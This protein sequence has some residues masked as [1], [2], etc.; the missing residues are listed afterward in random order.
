MAVFYYTLNVDNPGYHALVHSSFSWAYT[1]TVKQGDTIR[2]TLKYPGNQS[3][4]DIIQFYSYSP[5]NLDMNSNRNSPYRLGWER[6]SGGDPITSGITYQTQAIATDNDNYIRGNFFARRT[7]GGA[8]A[9]LGVRFLMV[10]TDGTLGFDVGSYSAGTAGTATYRATPVLDGWMRG[11]YLTSSNNYQYIPTWE[12]FAGSNVLS[13]RWSGQ[14]DSEA[15]ASFQMGNNLHWKIVDSTDSHVNSNDFFTS[16]GTLVSPQDGDTITIHPKS[17]V[18]GTYYLNLYHFNTEG[19]WSNGLPPYATNVYGYDYELISQKAFTVS[20][21]TAPTLSSGAIQYTTGYLMPTNPVGMTPGASVTY[22]WSVETRNG[23]KYFQSGYAGFYSS[24]TAGVGGEWHGS[25]WT[26]YAVATLGGNSATSNTVTFTLPTQD[27]NVTI[28]PQF[29]NSN[30]SVQ[31]P[32]LTVNSGSNNNSTIYFVSSSPPLGSLDNMY[33]RVDADGQG[34]D[35]DHPNTIVNGRTF[36][37]GNSRHVRSTSGGAGQFMTDIPNQQTAG[38]YYIYSLISGM[39]PVI[40]AYTGRSYI[41]ERPDTDIT[42]TPSKTNIGSYA[43]R[44]RD[45]IS[46]DISN[47]IPNNTNTTYRLL[48]VAGT[49]YDPYNYSQPTVEVSAANGSWVATTISSYDFDPNDGSFASNLRDW[50]DLPADGHFVEY[51]CQARIR[52]DRGGVGTETAFQ[53]CPGATFT[54]TVGDAIVAPQTSSLTIP[55]PNVS[56]NTYTA[57]LTLSNAG[58]G[59]G[60]LQYAIERNDSTPDNWVNA[61]YDSQTSFDA[62][63][64]RMNSPGTLYGHARRISGS[65]IYSA[66]TVQSITALSYLSPH[67]TNYYVSSPTLTSNN[68]DIAYNAS[69]VTI[70]IMR[71]GGFAAHYETTYKL[72]QNNQQVSSSVTSAGYSSTSYLS[73]TLS[74]T[75]LPA[76]SY[77]KTYQLTANRP[78]NKGGDGADKN[79][80]LTFNITRNSQGTTT[81]PT[82]PTDPGQPTGDY[83]LLVYGPDGSTLILSPNYR[84]FNIVDVQ[85]SLGFVKPNGTET[86]NFKK[87]YDVDVEFGADE[88]NLIIAINSQAS[89]DG[90]HFGVERAPGGDKSV[91][92]IKSIN[93]GLWVNDYLNIGWQIIRI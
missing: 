81:D 17:S 51:Q 83:G 35:F 27:E 91:V 36:D 62:T 11:E 72:K 42:V 85:T 12:K 49:K 24:P 89:F 90:A 41:V 22:Y 76:A 79:T 2:L 56:S 93:N 15:V 68:L 4:N 66:S 61:S 58:S 26:V 38:T 5:F 18:D 16:S 8:A 29:L 32:T 46:V 88:D 75:E 9:K 87:Y 44:A 74:G 23:I 14:L 7:N 57:R 37:L 30:S 31:S 71:T 21:I 45:N 39:T 6:V 33:R 73:F 59:G 20:G 10:P 63:F 86:S 53:N 70:R 28:S 84:A 64:D 69:S 77:T 19:D 13:K 34:V 3:V 25:T 40:V 48:T 55:S 50:Q 82:D 47:D 78:Q 80:N 67:T 60:Q 92:R 54:I 52:A 1:G 65:T 43:V